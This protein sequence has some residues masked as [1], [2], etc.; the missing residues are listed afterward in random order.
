Y[1]VDVDKVVD[2]AVANGVIIELNASPMRLDMDWRHWRKAAEKGVLTSINPD[3]HRTSQLEYFRTG[4]GAARKGWMT[5]Q[6]VFNTWPLAE[7][8]KWLAARR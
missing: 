3:A 7:V 2:A 5:R 1:D 4:V 6:Q 8:Q